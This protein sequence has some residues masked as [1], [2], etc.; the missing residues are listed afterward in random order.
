MKALKDAGYPVRT[1][2]ITIEEAKESIL[3]MLHR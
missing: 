2:A 1:D 3:E